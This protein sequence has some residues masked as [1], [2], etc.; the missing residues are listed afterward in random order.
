[1]TPNH[2]QVRRMI[3]DHIGASNAVPGSVLSRAIGISPKRS[4]VR[5]IVHDLRMRGEPICAN[6]YGYFMPAGNEEVR[7]A[8]EVFNHRIAKIAQ[9]RDALA[10]AAL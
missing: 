4:T 6:K 3:R 7:V 9:A 10:L 5:D 2:T 8:L 1:M